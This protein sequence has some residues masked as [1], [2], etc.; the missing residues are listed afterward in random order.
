MNKTSMTLTA[1]A[2]MACAS[3]A[4]QALPTYGTGS[5][6]YGAITSTM[7]AVQTTSSFTMV[8]ANITPQQVSASGSMAAVTLPASLAV[9]SPL[10][11]KTASA[12]TFDFSDPGLG[13][14]VATTVSAQLSTTANFAEYEVDGVFTV[15]SDFANAG[16]TFTADEAWSMT[17]VKGPNSSISMSGT[18][19]APLVPVTIPEPTTLALLG[20]GLAGL[21]IARRRKRKS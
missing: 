18:F 12:A 3:T 5:F 9:T 20:S 21:A 17:Q 4:A 15:G 13:S 19:F 8:P 6:A 16:K 10:V 7:S 2:V 1:A 11:F 14:F